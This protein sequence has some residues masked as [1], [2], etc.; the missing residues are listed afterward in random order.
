MRT[1]LLLILTFFIGSIQS[2]AQDKDTEQDPASPTGP[3]RTISMIKVTDSIFML[4]GKGGNIGLSKGEDGVL[5][6]D[7]Q[8]ADVTPELLTLV[9]TLTRRPVQFLVNTHHH[10]DHTGGNSNMLDTGTIIYAHEN[11]RKRLLNTDKRKFLEAQE[12]G[13]AEMVKNLEA[14]GSKEKAKAKV[15]EGNQDLPPFIPKKNTYPTITF[16]DALTFHYNGEDI[17]VFHVHNAHTDGDVMVYFTESNVLHTG[18]V[19]FNSKYPFVD[20]DSGGTYDGY[21]DALSKALMLIDDETKIIPGHGELGTKADVTFSRN[22]MVSLR[23]R[24]F[25]QY[26]N[27]KTKEEILAMK[28]ITKEFDAKGFGDGYISTE[29]FLELIYEQ[30]RRKYGVIKK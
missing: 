4:K 8:F 17:M 12:A 7:N 29:K 28:E 5:M 24:V 11:V 3:R 19:F 30:A 16:S 15:K 6:I 21:I 1:L 14:E 23:D 2:F 26:L 22:M 25:Y 10:G 13:F 9:N 27:K 20:I 18:D